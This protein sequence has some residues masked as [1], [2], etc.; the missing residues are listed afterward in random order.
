MVIAGI[1]CGVIG[2][3]LVI[4]VVVGG[5]VCYYKRRKN[6]RNKGYAPLSLNP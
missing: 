4:L 6:H 2:G 3:V 1:I 5:L